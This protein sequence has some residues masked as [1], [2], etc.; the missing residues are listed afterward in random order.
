MCVI[1]IFFL[2]SSLLFYAIQFATTITKSSGMG[3][4]KKLGIGFGQKG[5][6][7]GQRGPRPHVRWLRLIGATRIDT[8]VVPIGATSALQ[9]TFRAKNTFLQNVQTASGVSLISVVFNTRFQ[10]VD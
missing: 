5:R 10:E 1:L 9:D 8:E 2:L 4:A 3:L 7:A 6:Q